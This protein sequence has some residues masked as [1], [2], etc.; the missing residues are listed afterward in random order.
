MPRHFGDEFGVHRITGQL[1]LDYQRLL[2]SRFVLRGRDVAEFVHAA[3]YVMLAEPGPVGIDDR[4]VGGRRFGQSGEHRCLGDGNVFERL[5]EINLCGGSET[6]GT[7]TKENLIDIQLKNLVFCQIAFYLERQQGF[8]ELAGIG[9]F[10]SQ[11]EVAGNLLGDGRSALAFTAADQVGAD[12]TQ[13]A[14]VI[15]AAML[16][17]AIVF[18]RQDG[19]LHDRWYVLNRDHGASF[20]AVFANQEAVGGVNTQR[21]LRPVVSQHLE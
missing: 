19:L 12:G 16:V 14:G 21:D 3:Q 18:C 13:D 4:V 2:E 8:I 5:A 7:L 20:L 10:A 1:A 15:D 11:E 17:E 9:L 6:I